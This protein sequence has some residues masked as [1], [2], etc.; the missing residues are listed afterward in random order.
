MPTWVGQR[1]LPKSPTVKIQHLAG[2]A[3]AVACPL[4]T[5]PM[6]TLEKE[7]D[8][9]L[10]VLDDNKIRFALAKDDVVLLESAPAF[11]SAMAAAASPPASAW[12]TRDARRSPPNPKEISTNR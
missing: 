9:Q 6:F 10:I 11:F 3:P 4:P 7:A 5:L 2:D 12:P 1:V 8:G